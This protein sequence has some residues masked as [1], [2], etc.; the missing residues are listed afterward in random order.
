MVFCKGAVLTFWGRESALACTEN[1]VPFSVSSGGITP[2]LS[3]HCHFYD[4]FYDSMTVFGLG[5]VLRGAALAA[6]SGTLI[7]GWSR[8]QVQ[9]L[10]VR[11]CQS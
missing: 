6:C 4:S 2:A 9:I 1:L 5:T 8:A 7:P 3:S 11:I 10:W